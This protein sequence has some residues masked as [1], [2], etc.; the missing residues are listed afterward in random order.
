M[1]IRVDAFD[2]NDVMFDMLIA[3][4]A[5][6]LIIPE[7]G[8]VRIDGSFIKLKKESI[9]KLIDILTNEASN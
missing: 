4:S 9:N 8:A 2:D 6:T 1:L 7:E 5:V 3:P